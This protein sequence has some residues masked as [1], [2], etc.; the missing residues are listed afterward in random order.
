MQ[1]TILGLIFI[2][3]IMSVFLVQMTTYA[4]QIG[5]P[6]A[7]EGPCPYN[8]TIYHKKVLPISPYVHEYPGSSLTS[9]HW[10]CP[11]FASSYENDT[12]VFTSRYYPSNSI[13]Q[14]Q[15][16]NN[17]YNP[18]YG[19]VW[20]AWFGTNPDG[21]ITIGYGL[22]PSN[23]YSGIKAVVTEQNNHYY[24]QGWID[25]CELLSANVGKIVPG[26]IYTLAFA[27]NYTTNN[28]AFIWVNATGTYTYFLTPSL[29]SGNGCLLYIAN[30]YYSI[31]VQSFNDESLYWII[32]QVF[33]N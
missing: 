7:G 30:Q 3:A 29:G 33:V 4:Y 12:I 22:S 20:T 24:L 23:Q 1:R 21:Q 32:F 27:Y 9:S 2:T 5:E 26:D 18:F 14:T 10:S 16:N 28:I 31:N 11:E 15:S 13:N 25:G 6:G 8:L 19:V 17:E